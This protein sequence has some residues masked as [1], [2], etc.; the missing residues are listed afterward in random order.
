[1]GGGVGVGCHGS[2]RV[3]GESS[4]RIAMPEC[5]IGLIPDVGGSLLLA[6]APGRLGEYLGTTGARMGPGDA[7]EAGFADYYVPEADV[8]RPD[9]GARAQR[10]MAQ[11]RRRGRA[12]RRRQ[13]WPSSEEKIDALFRRRDAARHPE[14]ARRLERADRDRGAARRCE[15]NAPLSMACAVELIHRVRAIDTIEGALTLEHRFTWRAMEHGGLSGGH[16]RRDH[17][18]GPDTRDGASTRSAGAAGRS[19]ADAGAAGAGRADMGGD[20]KIG[21]IGLGNMGAPMAANLAKAGHDVA[22]YDV[23]TSSVE[24]VGQA[25]SAAEA[26]AGRGGR[27]HDAAERRHPASGRATRSC[28]PWSAAPC[29]STARR[30]TSPAPATWR[31]WRA[32]EG[33]RPLDA[34][35]S[36][37]TG[38]ARGGHA[39]LHGRRRGRRLRDGA[40]ALRRRWARRRFIADR[41][42]TAR[43]RRS[44]TT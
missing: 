8:A 25:A 18:Q 35:V 7:I 27:H 40:P 11:D 9:R 38:G 29:S 16:P 19:V 31:R 37:G 33:L 12:L 43:R 28:R 13:N 21:F 39:D 6:R 15:R 26:A 32:A 36:G 23:A 1:M 4:S 17:R 34:P 44:A 5:G 42:A 22:G 30:S 14:R 24:G 41:R 20:M 10:R 2:H 3:V